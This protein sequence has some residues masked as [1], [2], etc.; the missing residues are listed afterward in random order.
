MLS[1]LKCRVSSDAEDARFGSSCKAEFLKACDLKRII[2]TKFWLT[3]WQTPITMLSVAIL[4]RNLVL[5]QFQM[6][7]QNHC[8]MSLTEILLLKQAKLIPL[9]AGKSSECL[10]EYGFQLFQV[11]RLYGSETKKSKWMGDYVL[12]DQTVAYILP[13]SHHYSFQYCSILFPV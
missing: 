2:E 7:S 6:H 5:H 1:F 11:I 8:Q 13:R 3:C 10:M 9:T 12:C 4:L